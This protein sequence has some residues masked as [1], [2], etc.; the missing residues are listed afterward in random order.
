M[1]RKFHSTIPNSI[2]VNDAFILVHFTMCWFR[3]RARIVSAYFSWMCRTDGDHCVKINILKMLASD[4]IFL[5]LIL[6][7]K[8]AFEKKNNNKSN[9][10]CTS[11]LGPSKLGTCNSNLCNCS[12]HVY[13]VLEL[14]VFQIDLHIFF[15]AIYFGPLSWFSFQFGFHSNEL[16]EKNQCANCN[17]IQIFWVFYWLVENV[18]INECLPS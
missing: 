3:Y 15:I 18:E 7:V 10:N 14:R 1:Y 16:Q 6:F 8:H 2:L 4:T 12:T 17:Q 13:F 11:K 5:L 9:T